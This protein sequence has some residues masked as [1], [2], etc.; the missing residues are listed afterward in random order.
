MQP[1]VAEIGSFIEDWARAEL[2]SDV[3]RLRGLLHEAF[4]GVTPRGRTLD[5]AAW[6]QRYRAG[7]L[8][9]QVFSWRTLAVRAAAET[10]V[11][12]GQLDQISSYDGCDA[13]ASLTV[14]LA[15]VPSGR[16]P[17]LLSFHASDSTAQ[18][19]SWPPEPG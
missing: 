2:R 1:A 14:S 10:V 7:D 11:V 8:V 13:S 3:S 12:V 18:T 5:K 16:R 17:Q 4:V 15:V 19:G 6:L 9:N